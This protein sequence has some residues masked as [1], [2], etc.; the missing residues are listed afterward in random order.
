MSVASSRREFLR[1]SKLAGDRILHR[2][3]MAVGKIGQ[4][5]GIFFGPLVFDLMVQYGKPPFGYLSLLVL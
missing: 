5:A 2:L 4:N 3:A 1:C